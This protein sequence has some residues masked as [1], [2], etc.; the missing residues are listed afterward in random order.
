MREAAHINT[1]YLIYLWEKVYEVFFMPDATECK[2]RILSEDYQ[3]FII[4]SFGSFWKDLL[5]NDFCQMQLD[6]S[7]QILYL[8]QE[9]IG[10][11]QLFQFPYNS[12]PRCYAPLD[13]EALQ[14]AGIS[15]VQSLP[16]LEISGEGV[17]IGFLDSGINYKDPVF[18]NLDGTTRI[19]S[20][21][22]QTIQTGNPPEGIL[23]GSEYTKEQIDEALRAEN[24]EEIVPSMDQDGHGTFMAS[25]ACGSGNP[26]NQFLGAAPEADIMVVKLKEAKQYLR[27]FYFIKPEASCYQENDVMAALFYLYHAA[28]NANKP[29]VVCVTLGSNMGGHN[30][31]N[32]LSAYMEVMGNHSGIGLAAGVGNEADKRHHY[33]GAVTSNSGEEIEISVGD[34]VA[35]FTMELWTDIPNIFAV[36]IISPTGEQ[37]RRIAIREG[38]GM[39]NFVFENTDVYVV[40]RL[41]VETTNSQ[42]IFLRFAHP[43]SGIWRVRVEPIQLENGSFHAWLPMEEF[44]TGEVYFLRSN[45]DYTITAPGNT[46]AAACVA[47]YNG[48]DNSIAVSSGRGYTRLNEIKPDFAAPGVGVTGVNLRGQF[49]TRSGSSVAT[50]LTAGAEALLMEWLYGEGST[51]DSVQLKNYLILGAE[52]GSGRMYP[53]REW[54]YGTLDLYHTFEAVRRL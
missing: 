7:Y 13:M 39:Y 20:I 34:R 28:R 11:R 50:A 44:L 43:L 21:W 49:T 14:Q 52:R 3:D 54:G 26:E 45:P 47:Y 24:P 10:S 37:S 38:E 2:Q 18:R 53:N 32:P 36:S 16:G 33:M 27:D 19:L 1:E 4:R 40:Y 9:N 29:L 22:D 31:S 12:I 30:G 51:P 5:M 46:K 15:E 41:L 42:L 6:Y 35:G 8:G 23:Y 17:I 48:A 25:I